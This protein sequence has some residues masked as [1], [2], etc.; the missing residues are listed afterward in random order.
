MNLCSPIFT[1]D[2]NSHLAL[3]VQD[4]SALEPYH[5]IMT[6]IK[7]FGTVMHSAQNYQRIL[8]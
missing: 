5:I 8:P 4:P 6:G 1:R 7:Q 2:H 3:G